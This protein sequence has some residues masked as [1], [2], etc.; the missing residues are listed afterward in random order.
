MA[1]NWRVL[2][3]TFFS[4]SLRFDKKTRKMQAIDKGSA[5][6]HT[7]ALPDVNILFIGLNA[8]L[9]PG[10][11]YHLAKND[12]V[13]VFCDWK[14]L[15]ISSLYPWIDAHGRVAARQRAQASLSLPRTKNAWMRI[16]KAKITGQ[17]NVLRDFGSSKYQELSSMAGKVKSGDP[18]NREGQAARVYWRSLFDDD[19]F[20]RRPGAHE[21][22]VNALLDYGY[23]ILRGHSMRAVLS[24]GLTPALG[25]YHKGRSNAF[26][27]AD[28]LIE[29]FRPAVDYAVA[30]FEPKAR[31][32]NKDSRLAILTACV[33]EFGREP[34]TIPTV[35]VE[36]AQHYGQYVEGET[37]TLAVPVYRPKG[38]C[39]HEN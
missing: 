26:A 18:D 13:T 23:T 20:V 27:L 28:D 8:N 15:P 24:A 25:L 10:M 39:G 6:I 34:K 30:S 16:I 21:N 7:Y 36:F 35:M 11:A 32:I 37:K 29:P 5:E 38:M 17:A 4:G 3:L 22:G 19:R 31:T 12:V 14:G 9:S 1:S 33:G 2:D